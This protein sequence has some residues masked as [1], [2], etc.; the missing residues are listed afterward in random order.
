MTIASRP[1]RISN[2]EREQRLDNLRTAM[3]ANGLD[4]ILIT[5]GSNMR[6][7]RDPCQIPDGRGHGLLGGA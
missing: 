3:S 1:P 4:A 2:A 7:I 6:G 5:P